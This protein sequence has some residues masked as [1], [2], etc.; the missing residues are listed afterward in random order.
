MPNEQKEYISDM[1]A[2]RLA[3]M[4]LA[5]KEKLFGTPEGRKRYEEWHLKE[6]GTLPQ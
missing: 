2:L 5:M 6:Y 3:E 1:T 4:L